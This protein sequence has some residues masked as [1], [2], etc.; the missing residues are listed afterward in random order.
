MLLL[1]A[2]H[3]HNST[4]RRQRPLGR[5]FKD[6]IDDFLIRIEFHILDYRPMTGRSQSGNRH[7][8][9]RH[10]KLLQDDETPPASNRSFATY[11]PPGFM[12]AM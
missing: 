4:V 1:H 3:F 12:S 7:A 10:Q 9:S 6:A 5:R 2:S 8:G 11:L